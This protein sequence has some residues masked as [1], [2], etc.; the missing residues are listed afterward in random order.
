MWASLEE[1][2]SHKNNWNNWQNKIIRQ[3][4]NGSIILLVE[5]LRQNG[6]HK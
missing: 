6:Y 3:L 5:S 4:K 1:T 2:I